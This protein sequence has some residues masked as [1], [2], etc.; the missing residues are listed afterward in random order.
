MKETRSLYDCGH[1]KVEGESIACEQGTKLTS[2]NLTGTISII[3]L[4]RGSPLELRAC[5]HCKHFSQM[6]GGRVLPQDRGWVT[7]PKTKRRKQ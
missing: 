6:D 7:L 2:M 4:Q 5:Q 3:R 1:A